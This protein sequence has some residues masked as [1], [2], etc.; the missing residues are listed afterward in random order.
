MKPIFLIFFIG[1]WVTMV[2]G[3]Q[4]LHS[5]FVIFAGVLGLIYTGVIFSGLSP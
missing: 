2:S 1:L 3:P 5:A 4:S